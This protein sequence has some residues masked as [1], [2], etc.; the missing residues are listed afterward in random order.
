[1]VHVPQPPTCERPATDPNLSAPASSLL[2]LV[3][4]SIYHCECLGAS[5]LSW[6]SQTANMSG[7]QARHAALCL[8]AVALQVLGQIE[9]VHGFQ[10]SPSNYS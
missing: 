1:M 3:R 4:S 10:F 8:P 5:H 2:L 9:G 6:C 7:A